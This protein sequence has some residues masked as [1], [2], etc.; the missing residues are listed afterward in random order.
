MKVSH[1]AV[2]LRLGPPLRHFDGQVQAHSYVSM[3][4]GSGCDKEQ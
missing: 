4:P 3:L 2:V 1:S